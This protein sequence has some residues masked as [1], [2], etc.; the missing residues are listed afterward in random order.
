MSDEG[1]R[2]GRVARGFYLL[3]F[4]TFLLLTTQDVLPWSFWR[5]VL[6]YWPVF[7]VGI[8]LRL[9]FERSPA[10]ALVLLGPILVLGMMMYV[11]MR[12]PGAGDA[13]RDWV[14]VRVERP[15][16][17]QALTLEGRLARATLEVG[18]RRLPRG[19]LVEGRASEGGR[20]AIRVAESG[21]PGRVRVT[22]TWSDHAFLVLPGGAKDRCELGVS[23]AL[24]ITFDLDLAFTATRL[25]VAAGPLAGLAVGGAFNDLHLR[26]GEPASDVRLRLEGAFNQVTLEVPAATPVRVSSEGFLNVVDERR[27]D[28]GRRGGGAGPPGY[29][30]RLQGAFNR[31]V[32]RTW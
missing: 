6:A 15:D 4:G 3:G 29:R 28:A 22:N 12:A 32:V 11:A 7:L 16:G 24:P 2:W 19:V 10:P 26:L 21:A 18:S 14:P 23:A 27:E 31:V 17:L 30:L 25:D 8:G 5:D 1:I 20:H 13:G 9:V